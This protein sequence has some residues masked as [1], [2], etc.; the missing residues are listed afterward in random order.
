MDY[1]AA[2]KGNKPFP[3]DLILSQAELELGHPL[4]D[5][6]KE[7]LCSVSSKEAILNRI[8]KVKLIM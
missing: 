3:M 6:E 4:T 7:N 2:V 1:S 5:A 8:Q